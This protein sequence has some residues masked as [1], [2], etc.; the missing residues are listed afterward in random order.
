[1]LDYTLLYYKLMIGVFSSVGLWHCMSQWKDLIM[2]Q[3]GASAGTVK[4]DSTSHFG[5]RI[6]HSV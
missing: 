2:R 1:M 3:T 6:A 5:A 4:S